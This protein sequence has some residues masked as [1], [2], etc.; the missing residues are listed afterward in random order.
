MIDRDD[1]MSYFD[2][3]NKK[4]SDWKISKLEYDYNQHYWVDNNIL[5]RLGSSSHQFVLHRRDLTG[6]N[7]N[8]EWMSDVIEVEEDGKLFEFH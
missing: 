5:F 1:N 4:W 7:Q 3:E 2:L 8:N 6:D